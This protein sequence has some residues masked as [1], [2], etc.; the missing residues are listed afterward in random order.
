MLIRRGSLPLAQLTVGFSDG[1][2]VSKSVLSSNLDEALRDLPRPE[3]SE[4]SPAARELD[5]LLGNCAASSGDPGAEVLILSGD[6]DKVPASASKLR[7]AE[8]TG[9]KPIAPPSRERFIVV[10]DPTATQITVLLAQILPPQTV[11][12]SLAAEL[13]T[14]ALRS[15]LMNNLRSAK[16]WSYE[17]YPF[18]V[19]L[20]PGG[21]VARFNIPLQSDKA[22]EAITEVR[23]EIARLHDE[24]VAPEH[25]GTFKSFLEGSLTAGLMSLEQLNAQALVI[26]RNDRALDSPSKA[27]ARLQTFTAEELQAAAKELLRSDRLLWIVSGKRE[28]VERELRELGVPFELHEAR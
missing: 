20:R 3:K 12:D 4:Q 16:G 11:K 21:A 15:R 22:A 9:V 2:S 23:K 17:V 18:G 8:A 14:H 7:A 13:V 6:V 5:C 28:E 27:L 25:L 1:T 24:P 19:E 10:D 26:A